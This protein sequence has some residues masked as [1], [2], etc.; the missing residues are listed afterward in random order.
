MTSR[1]RCNAYRLL[2]WIPLAWLAACG[3]GGGD[4]GGG[5]GT[6]PVSIGGTVSG[7]AGTG[8]VL[9]ST[10]GDSLAIAANGAFH[11]ATRLAPGSAYGVTVSGQPRSPMQWCDVTGGSGTAGTTDVT[12]ISVTCAA[13]APVVHR[14]AIGATDLAWEAHAGTL[15]V[16]LGSGAPQGANSVAVVDPATGVLGT[17]VGAGMSP[18]V[19]RVSDDGTLLY[20]GSRTSTSIQRFRL[21][22][23]ASDLTIPLG[24][25]PPGGPG[26]AVATQAIEVQP[27]AAHTIAVSRYDPTVSVS[28]DLVI[29]D[30]ATVRGT[31]R[32]SIPPNNPYFIAWSADGATAYGAD[33]S[34]SPPTIGT[35]AIGSAGAAY[36]SVVVGVAPGGA[37]IS[38]LA[39]KLYTSSG[40]VVDPATKDVVG[41]VGASGATVLDVGNGLWFV[42]QDDFTGGTLMAYDLGHF[43][44]VG[45]LALGVIPVTFPATTVTHAVRIGSDG[46]AMVTSGGDLLVIDHALTLPDPALGG[47]GQL[48]NTVAGGTSYAVYDLPA[49]SLA[50]APTQGL[51]YASLPSGAKGLGN[52]IAAFDPVAGAVTTSTYVGSEPAQL[53]LSGDGTT[54]YAALAGATGV[55]QVAVP[56]LA[57]GPTLR[58]GDGTIYPSTVEVAPGS[59][60]TLAI[61][62]LDRYVMQTSV[63]VYDGATRRA[64]TASADFDFDV[65]WGA[66]ASTLYRLGGATWRYVEPLAVDAGGVAHTTTNITSLS[67]TGP[68]AM[69]F[70]GGLLYADDGTIYDPASRTIRASIPGGTGSVLAVDAAS[71]L[72]FFASNNPSASGLVVAAVDLAHGNT[73]GR[74]A[75]PDVTGQALQVVRWG[76]DGLALATTTG[77]LVIV[78]GNLVTTPP[79]ADPCGGA[80][81]TLS[82]STGPQGPNYSSLRVAAGATDIVADPHSGLLFASIAATATAG[83]NCVVPLVPAT[84]SLGAGAYA[85]SR[86]GPL[87]VAGDGSL[88]YAA[89]SGA[90]SIERFA[91]SGLAHDLSIPVV[92]ASLAGIQPFAVDID[93]SPAAPAT[94]AATL[95]RNFQSPGSVA[96]AVYDNA[97]ARTS[98]DTGHYIDAVQWTA[99]GSGLYGYDNSAGSFDL[100]TLPVTSAG[101]ATA[102]G[103]TAVLQQTGGHIHRFGSLVYGD[104]G[105]V[106]DP[107]TGLLAGSFSIVA[108]F[109][110][111]PRSVMTADIAL[112]CAYL[113]YVDP[114]TGLLT[115]Q[116][117]GLA[118]YASLRTIALAAVPGTPQRIVR[119]GASGL[120]LLL[121]SGDIL[122]L[123]GTFV[124]G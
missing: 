111:A 89:L 14:Y 25:I 103:V 21:P 102:T 10:T 37:G 92:P 90:N 3:G 12:S 56:S 95:T 17:V 93:V 83:A 24:S 124:T 15:Y 88:L 29:F 70:A 67:A 68:R 40:R 38:S 64:A 109:T 44:P 8:L 82:T 122:L 74:L 79:P 94:I 43:V 52:S 75:L 31:P 69:H 5:G 36:Q 81:G 101:V 11:F 60:S 27:G 78:R 23:L 71:G 66:D 91:V 80:L 105:Q 48:L 119:W 115:V 26:S 4:G 32:T 54:L 112:G 72:G 49:Q 42:A 34:M 85:G 46:L 96:L 84:G 19:I 73:V 106:A 118:N 114:A 123:D 77:Q 51:L 117:F 7:L 99:D 28:M 30:D 47:S 39:G 97:S 104:N 98:I 2:G 116:A 50:W 110:P 57:P 59:S 35:Y 107:A 62:R 100:Y 113:A 58:L 6:A 45:K 108:P 53:A 16:A 33:N 63:A 41:T 55:A 87:A 22:G 65:Q 121:D 9:T 120:A 20:A 13:P 61:V 76:S 18:S 1:Q 86:P